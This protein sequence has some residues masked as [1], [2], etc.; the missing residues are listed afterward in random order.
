MDR[1]CWV[2]D[3]RAMA[4]A[5]PARLA[6]A[7][8]GSAAA[9]AAAVTSTRLKDPQSA[10]CT[11][12][13]LLPPALV[14]DAADSLKQVRPVSRW[15]T[16]LSRSTHV[17]VRAIAAAAVLVVVVSSACFIGRC[18]GGDG[19]RRRKRGAP[20]GHTARTAHQAMAL[21]SRAPV[22]HDDVPADYKAA[23]VI[24]YTLDAMGMVSSVLLGVEER[25]V[26]LKDLGDSA[27]GSAKLRVLLFP[28][29]KRENE[30]TGYVDTARREFEEETADPTGLMSW[31]TGD[32]ECR[33]AVAWNPSAKMAVIFREV[34]FASCIPFPRDADHGG[35]SEGSVGVPPSGYRETPELPMKPLWV[36][37][38][39]LRRTLL[40]ESPSAEVRTELG[41]F[42]LFPMTRRFF[43][44][45]AAMRWLGLE[46]KPKSHQGKPQRQRR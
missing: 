35:G 31:L 9:A 33:C 26:Q 32:E 10:V 12:I 5:P 22:P 11:S 19:G 29:G 37:A 36:D 18:R 20:R 15:R 40:A 44:T 43:R 24:F 23:G 34:P 46:P 42:P 30:D 38:L 41:S 27:G 1:F 4:T 16:T 45:A 25:K 8:A 3:A 39:E 13:F 28:Q 7:A 6:A 14:L 21:P 17:A 2:G